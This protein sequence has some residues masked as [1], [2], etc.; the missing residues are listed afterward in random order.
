MKRRFAQDPSGATAVEFALVFPALASLFM[1]TVGFGITLWYTNVLQDTATET[2]RCIA[3][4][5]SNCASA[6]VGCDSAVG[7]ICFAETVAKTYGV[8][9]LASSNIAIT[10]AYMIGTLSFTQVKISYPVAIFGYSST[11]VATGV[12]PN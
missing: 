2:A 7:G 8:K 9:D 3:I 4:G 1:A 6:T 11:L 5:S 10:S 12:Y